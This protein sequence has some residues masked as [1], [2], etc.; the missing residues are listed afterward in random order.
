MNKVQEEYEESKRTSKNLK[1]LYEGKLTALEE[2]HEDEFD[3]LRIKHKEM[4]TELEKKWND[5]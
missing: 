4:K 2:E 3:N 5:L 1:S